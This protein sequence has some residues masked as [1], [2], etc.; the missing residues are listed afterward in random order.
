MTLRAEFILKRK[1]MTKE[2][3]LELAIGSIEEL[4]A[5][6]YET[7]ALKA[8]FMTVI[9]GTDKAIDMFLKKT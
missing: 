9:T 2:E 7:S 6:H 5:R 3:L 8:I 1:T 4:K